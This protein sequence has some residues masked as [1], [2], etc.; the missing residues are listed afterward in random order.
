M[1]NRNFCFNGISIEIKQY[2][3]CFFLFLKKND[4]FVTI[5]NTKR[6]A[7]KEMV[8]D[9]E[10]L[11][12]IDIGTIVD[13]MVGSMESSE[14]KLNASSPNEIL[15]LYNLIKTTTNLKRFYWYNP[16]MLTTLSYIRYPSGIKIVEA[17][18]NN[19]TQNN[20]YQIVYDEQGFIL[21]YC[22][23]VLE[24][25]TPPPKMAYKAFSETV[26]VVTSKNKK[27]SEVVSRNGYGNIMEEVI[28]NDGLEIELLNGINRILFGYS[29]DRLVRS[30]LV[31]FD[32]PT[33]IRLLNDM[34]NYLVKQ[35]DPT[36]EINK[37]QG[38]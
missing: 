26:T 12:P 9:A 35:I 32:I 10:L 20:R 4:Y 13:N 25:L 33:T 27:F 6:K 22:D 30:S 28:E 7:V 38:L 36:T 17:T 31:D 11:K 37:K 2:Y 16:E 29:K 14:E 18:M 5:C 34:R 3:Y 8:Y 24:K 19:D 23:C 21:L 1:F 15:V